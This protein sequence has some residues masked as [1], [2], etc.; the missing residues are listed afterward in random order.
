M[1]QVVVERRKFDEIDWKR[2][3][4]FTAFG[5]AYLGG[6]QYVMY[7]HWL[8]KFFNAQVV[9]TFGTQS[10]QAKIKNLPGMILA[11]KQTAFDLTIVSPFVYYTSF[12]CI[13]EIVQVVAEVGSGRG[14]YGEFP[15]IP[16]IPLSRYF[17]NA[18]SKWK[19]N[20]VEDNT[21][22]VGFWF[23]MNLVCFSVPLHF[24]LPAI[25]GFSLVWTV[26]LSAVR[27]RESEET[28]PHGAIDE[29]QEKNRETG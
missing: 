18:L 29:E 23:P 12:Y 1:A 11:L 16:S 9:K 2:N 27:G 13:K 26:G 20:F 3:T 4:L 10:L 17:S 15:S 7:V 6:L 22:M 25:H 8:P 24:R 28:P 5:F 19:R 21:A 14:E